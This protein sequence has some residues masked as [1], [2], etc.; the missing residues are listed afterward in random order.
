MKNDA[1][2][3]LGTD[4]IS[5][6]DVFAVMDGA[7]AVLDD[8]AIEEIR[9]ARQRVDD[10]VAQEAPVYGVNT[11]FGRLAD[12]HVP[13]ERLAELQENLVVS[14]AAGVGLPM[15]VA[16]VRAMM[17]L[18]VATFARG[19]S[20]PRLETVHALLAL[21]EKE[22]LPVIPWQ[23][24]VG[25][26]GDLAPLAHLACALI[27]RGQVRVGGGPLVPA[28]DALSEAGL[29]VVRLE[30]KEGLALTNG[31][32]AMT[33]AGCEGLRRGEHIAKVADVVCAMTVD[34]LLG[35][36]AAFD[37]RIHAARN[38]PGQMETADVIRGLL[39]ESPLRDSHR[40]CGK[41]QDAYSLR[42]APQVHGAVKDTLAHVRTVLAREIN[43][44]TDNPLIFDDAVLSGGNFH[45]APVAAVLDF[46]AI[47]MTD[48]A[49][50]SERR[51]ERMVNPDLSEG[52][53]PFLVRDS[54]VNSGFM[55]S[56]VTAAALVAESRVLSHPASVD[57]ISTS[58][59]QEDHVSM[60]LHAARK[61]LEVVTNVERVVAIE[62]MAACQALDLRGP[63][64]TSSPLEAV[65]RH[66]RS[67]VPHWDRDR[68]AAPDIETITEIVR[69]QDIL[70]L[71][72]LEGTP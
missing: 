51:I 38:H 27:G 6:D 61:A 54:G 10:I 58:A 67:Q 18:R 66:V 2:V 56:H 65:H 35:T 3:R 52:L 25:A 37:A 39:A 11:G 53:S 26:S 22:I 41:V 31:T 12:V 59:G 62:L 7:P 45:G 13:V 19:L 15:P 20:G 4:G 16:V 40:D 33:A 71:A 68:E 17:F 28:R 8:G 1:S 32:Q 21:L 5:L 9:R 24:S 29:D 69:G 43:A 30:A 34:A 64:T 36:D 50:I 57:S 49:S 72:G 55:L 60:G 47:S 23:G 44:V 42:C 63:L 48:L 46:L 70:Q 14:H